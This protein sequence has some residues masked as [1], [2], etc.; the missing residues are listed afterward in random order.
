[1]ADKNRGLRSSAARG[2]AG[3]GALPTAKPACLGT[4]ARAAP[5]ADTASALRVAGGMASTLSAPADVQATS[6]LPV[7]PALSPHREHKLNPTAVAWQPRERAVA[8][9]VPT[10]T[11]DAVAATVAATTPVPWTEEVARETCDSD[12]SAMKGHEPATSQVGDTEVTC[13]TRSVSAALGSGA[14]TPATTFASPEPATVEWMLLAATMATRAALNQDSEH[15]RLASGFVQPTTFLVPLLTA[16]PAHVWPLA[17][18]QHAR[19]PTAHASL[20]RAAASTGCPAV[21]CSVA[22]TSLVWDA[23]CE[24]ATFP[25]VQDGAVQACAQ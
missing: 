14:W 15:V 19:I 11:A 16:L 22:V 8:D 3:V 7:A 21:P 13:H 4:T 1:M 9:A 24:A 18:P 6:T 25:N 17:A 12:A 20:E 5:A 10:P 2:S 23:L